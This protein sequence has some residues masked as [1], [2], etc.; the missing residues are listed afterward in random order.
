MKLLII[1]VLYKKKLSEIPLIMD[2]NVIGDDIDIYIH[3]NSPIA[4]SFPERDNLIYFHSGDNK[5]VSY[6]Y[7]CGF[8]IAIK[9]NKDC[10]LLLD[11]DTT[12]KVKYLVEYDF[13]Y[14]KYANKFIYAPCICDAQK[15]K[16]YSP[17]GMNNFVGHILPYKK[18]TSSQHHIL[19]GYSAINSGLMIPLSIYQNI[20]GYNEN[21]PLDFSDI[22][23]IEKYKK[24]KKHLMLLPIEIVHS[25][26]G[27]EGY[28]K[29]RELYRFK[30]YCVGA[31]ELAKS[32]EKNTLYTV[33]RRMIRLVV[34]Y[35]TLNPLATV[36][37]Y[38][39]SDGLL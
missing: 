3:D 11:Q 36:A 9:N 24:I 32:V 37:K 30:F 35:R 28:D 1:L 17:A 20:G 4:Q 16:Q 26:S 19:D 7:N 33:I 2:E 22:Y 23:F 21:I 39:L 14:K 8:D 29:E 6:A 13:A 31:R 10:V 38:Y 12:F 34:K 27:D 5:G 18:I 25:L 15:S